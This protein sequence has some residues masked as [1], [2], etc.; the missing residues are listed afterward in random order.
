MYKVGFIPSAAYIG[1]NYKALLSVWV[2]A[3]QDSKLHISDVLK[4][5]NIFVEFQINLFV[6]FKRGNFIW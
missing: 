2:L 1:F 4:P 6:V 3:K 5:D